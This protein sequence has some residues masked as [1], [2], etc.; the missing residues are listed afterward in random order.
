MDYAANFRTRFRII[1]Q[2]NPPELAKKKKA[3]IRRLVHSDSNEEKKVALD[4]V[5]AE[6]L[7]KKVK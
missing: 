2:Q 6:E 7:L 1:D 4:I 5:W 3:D